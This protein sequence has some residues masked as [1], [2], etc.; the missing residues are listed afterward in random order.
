MAS[1]TIKGLSNTSFLTTGEEV[2]YAGKQGF[3]TRSGITSILCNSFF[4][5]TTSVVL[6]IPD[7]YLLTDDNYSSH[8][9][10][11]SEQYSSSEFTIT[12]PVTQFA[13]SRYKEGSVGYRDSRAFASLPITSYNIASNTVTVSTLSTSNPIDNFFTSLPFY[14]DISQAVNTDNFANNVLY[15]SGTS[16]KIKNNFNL[17]SQTASAYSVDLPIRTRA[18]NQVKVFLDDTPQTSFDW[19]YSNNTTTV[20]VPLS[21]IE[22]RLT[23]EV[24]LYTVPAIEAN[25][26]ISFSDSSNSFTVTNVSY[27][28]TD[29]FYDV[30]ATEAQIYKV[31]LDKPIESNVGGLR[32][33]NVSTDLV[34]SVGNVTANSFSLD[35]SD[36]YPYSYDLASNRIY[37]IYQ[38]N[39]LKTSTARLD[40]FGKL[41]S[42]SPGYYLVGGTNINRFN[43]T[44]PTVFKLLQVEPIKI[45]RVSSVS[46]TESIF[47]DTTGGASITA[48][49]EF[50]PIVGADVTHYDI[51]YSIQSEDETVASTTRKIT[52]DNDETA[53]FI[54]TNINNLNRGRTPGSNVLVVEVIP[55]NGLFS[56]FSYRT[57]KP[58]IGKT[59]PPR[60]LDDLNIG[61]QDNTLVF[62]WRFALTEDGFILDLDTKEVEIREYSGIIDTSNPATV[63]AAWAVSIPIERIPFPNTTFSLPISKYGDYTYLLRVKDTSD[64]ESET[65]AASSISVQRPI[66]VRLFK[67]YS[68]GSPD[69]SFAVQEG[70]PFPNSNAYPENSFPSVSMGVNGGLVLSDSTHVDNANGSSEGFSFIGDVITTQDSGRA[71][72]RTQIRDIGVVARGSIRISTEVSIDNPNTTFASQY[73]SVFAGITDEQGDNTFVL[74]D[75][76]FSGIGHILGF[77]NSNA[78]TVTYNSFHKT[79]T[80]GGALGNVYAIRNPGQY[81]GDEANTNAYCLIAGVVNSNAIVLGA[82]YHANGNPTGSNAFSNVTISGNSYELVNLFQYGD[83]EGSLTYLGEERSIVQN[84]FVRYSTDNVFYSAVSNGVVGL[85]G[86]GNTNP[87][88]FEGASTNAR[89]GFKNY[90]AGELDLRYFQLE[91]EIQNKRPSVSSVILEKLDYEFDIQEKTIT[92]TVN[93]TSVAGVAVDYSYAN[94]LE[95]PIIVAS[96]LDSVGSFDTSIS[97]VTNTSCNVQVFESQNGNPVD[98]ESVN[99]FIRGI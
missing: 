34:G 49:V 26:K 74:V 81:S 25:D 10:E 65:I 59:T 69:I 72:Y 88:A 37:F 57:T 31:K 11:A 52:V 73:S 13:L 55:K 28:S 22:N 96:M 53:S 42:A 63:E 94:L 4:A 87:F 79:L 50:P 9:L 15:I 18:K 12:V 46:I 92:K 14:V 68:E 97:S 75:N 39:K 23:T 62:S 7:L 82:S 85:P 29:T 51:L 32:V 54:T 21:G 83:L 2:V 77:D 45:G 99:L 98:T 24:S 43:R 90:V 17:S 47:I 56:G 91:V 89:A 44:S 67:A 20:S 16:K 78:A 58:L 3:T 71:I 30:S 70:V 95:P 64:L 35:Y 61:Q 36:S 6:S 8:V 48:T 38:K 66:N 41:A 60:G 19:A 40:E 33:I 84:I 93:V 86:H 76:A 5:N 80:S 27:S 1:Y